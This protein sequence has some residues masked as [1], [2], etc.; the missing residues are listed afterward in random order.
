MKKNIIF[1]TALLLVSLIIAN[2]N[3]FKQQRLFITTILIDPLTTVESKSAFKPD[4]VNSHNELFKYTG[5]EYINTDKLNQLNIKLYANIVRYLQN[6]KSYKYLYAKEKNLNSTEKKNFFK[7]VK[8]ISLE[9]A[10]FLN[11]EYLRTVKI[12]FRSN[13]ENEFEVFNDYLNFIIEKEV[14]KF[15][16]STTNFF[17]GENYH[18]WQKSIV[19]RINKKKKNLENLIFWLMLDYNDSYVE[20]NVRHLEKKYDKKFRL[21]MESVTLL[22]TLASKPHTFAQSNKEANYILK[23]QYLETLNQ[24]KI[25]YKLHQL[26]DKKNKIEDIEKKYDFKLPALFQSNVTLTDKDI[27]DF[28]F[29]FQ[30][31]YEKNKIKSNLN[32]E[33]IN[34]KILINKISDKLIVVEKKF[35][36][37]E[38]ISL[39]IFSIIFTIVSFALLRSFSSKK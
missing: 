9:G 15:L 10:Y 12:Q 17:Y 8:N 1:F 7:I 23:Y 24:A 32:N 4:L 33:V 29:Y 13:K 25:L 5:T 30:H 20:F 21:I 22:D 11:Y 18:R 35:N 31:A 28:L 16:L 36:L 6:N 26:N 37:K 2:Y 38:F 14:D 27:D 3:F 39:N 34:N 19:D